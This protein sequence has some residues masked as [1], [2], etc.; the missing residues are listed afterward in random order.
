MSSWTRTWAVARHNS[1]GCAA[2]E[3]C[4]QR[5]APG[6]IERVRINLE[7]LEPRFKV[8]GSDLWSDEAGFAQATAA[9]GITGVCG[10][11]IIEVI[12]E[13]YLAGIINQDGVL[14]GR[15]AARSPPFF[16]KGTGNGPVRMPFSW[17]PAGRASR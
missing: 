1:A 13:M 4:G 15:L 14:D 8:I 11:G 10:S 2:G 17:G 7:T 16:P 6:A 5:A 12:A 3:S 9:T